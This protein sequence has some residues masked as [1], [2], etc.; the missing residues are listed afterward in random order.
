MCGIL[1]VIERHRPIDR[2][3]FRAALDRIA[4]RGPDGMGEVFVTAAGDEAGGCHVAFGHRRLSILDL[5]DRSSQPFH[6][7]GALLTYNGE[8]Y[9]YRE[10]RERMSDS[11]Q[12]STDGDTEVLFETLRRHGLARLSLALGMWAFCYLDEARGKL[13]AARDRL[14]KKPLFYRATETTICIASEIGPIMSYM[15]TRPEIPVATVDTYLGYGWTLPGSGAD[16]PI[17]DIKQV[18]P[19][20]HLTIDLARWHATTG[21]WFDPTQWASTTTPP[22]HDLAAQVRAAV[23]DRLVSDRKV[24]LLLS[25]GIDSSLIL[26][27]LCAEGLQ[28][29]VHCFI[30]D[31]GKSADAEYAIRT[32][33]ALGVAA[34]VVPLD[35]TFGTM[36]RFLNIC[37]HQEKPFPMI[38]NALGLPE[39]YERIAATDVPVVLDGTGADE[40][41][42][43]YWE[44]Y[45]RFAIAEAWAANDHAW[46]NTSI[47]ANA[48]LTRIDHLGK[49]TIAAL[50]AGSWPPDST[51]GAAPTPAI[52]PLLE[53]FCRP[54]VAMSAPADDLAHFR[55]TLTEALHRDVTSGLL[56]EWLWQNDRNAMRSGVENRSPFLDTRLT[57]ALTTGYHRKF[58]GPWNKYELRQLFD[59]FKP[60]PTQWRREK[61]G[62]RWVFARFLRQ[63]RADVLEVIRASKLVRDRVHVDRLIEAIGHDEELLF[64]DLTQRCLCLAG[65]EAATGLSVV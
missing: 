23:V 29:Q 51:V 28:E 6:R 58:N 60:A 37:R 14:G 4:H 35:Y 19:S 64:S 62:F 63:N 41:F 25:G 61:Q 27:V 12:F 26:S 17:H 9:N 3:R 2:T 1:V 46:I 5:S 38:G 55:G 21:L 13:I 57:A 30:G 47:A 40:I 44:R 43:G 7:E 18:V 48:D 54:E 65:L 45:Y 56:P 36:S 59:R 34:E 16:T 49:S 15:G 39:L 24:G 10:L 20:G 52:L 33:E 53:T 8:I 22:P 42:G 50:K 32:I 31:A 11:T